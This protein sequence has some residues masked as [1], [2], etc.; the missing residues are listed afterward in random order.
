MSGD[1]G[2]SSSEG[3]GQHG[4]GDGSSS[5]A[6]NSEGAGACSAPP[7]QRLDR[8]A[9]CSLRGHPKA[10]CVPL[11]SGALWDVRADR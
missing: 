10:V 3:R 8:A 6:V 7:T 9:S 11:C 4:D 2:P 5:H 1:G